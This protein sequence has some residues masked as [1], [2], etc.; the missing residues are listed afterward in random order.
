MSTKEPRRKSATVQ[1]VLGEE[2]ANTDHCLLLVDH[3]P[4]YHSAIGLMLMESIMAWMV[5][6]GIFSLRGPK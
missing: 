1:E 4:R 5:F 6:S 2:F 3:S